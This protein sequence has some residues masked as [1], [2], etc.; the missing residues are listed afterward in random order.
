MHAVHFWERERFTCWTRVPYM[1]LKKK[2][3]EREIRSSALG[4]NMDTQTLVHFA[5]IQTN[6]SVYSIFHLYPFVP[7]HHTNLYLWVCFTTPLYADLFVCMSTKWTKACVSIFHPRAKACFSLSHTFF[8]SH[9]LVQQVN[10]SLDPK[11]ELHAS[12][13]HDGVIL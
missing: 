12:W 7:V 1:W 6:R 10:L 9:T 13:C 8:F 11:S 3:C 4:W 2:V 5:L